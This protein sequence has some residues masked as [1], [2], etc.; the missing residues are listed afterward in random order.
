MSDNEFD[1]QFA[2]ESVS[3]FA[4]KVGQLIQFAFFKLYSVRLYFRR[5]VAFVE[6]CVHSSVKIYAPHSRNHVD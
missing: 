5:S 4:Q 6:T 1:N 3:H 2:S